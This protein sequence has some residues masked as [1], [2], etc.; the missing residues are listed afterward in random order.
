MSDFELKFQHVAPGDK[1]GLGHGVF[2]Q[3][4][5]STPSHRELCTRNVQRLANE[6]LE[7]HALD[8]GLQGMWLS[9]EQGVFPFDL[10]W[11]NLILGPGGRI[12]SFVLNATHNSVMTPDLRHICGY[13][14]DPSCQLCFVKNMEGHKA[15]LHHILANCKYALQNKRYTW[16]HDSVVLTL[17]QAIQPVLLNHNTKPQ[18]PA[19]IPA[20]S[21]SFVSAGSAPKRAKR[22]H[23]NR[24]L[25]GSASDWKLLV[26]FDHK[27]YMFPP[28]ILATRERPG[29]LLFCN[30]LRANL[31]RWKDYSGRIGV[32][33][34]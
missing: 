2:T 6:Q 20:I 18:I 3:S 25:L 34:R 8:L 32:P 27:H 5:V 17:L 28:H 16:R 21:S 26:D 10:S 9:W 31:S 19:P 14:A 33:V 24:S 4:K 23:S 29:I 11:D 12:V 15:T 1:R 22:A 7:A 13:V 30:S